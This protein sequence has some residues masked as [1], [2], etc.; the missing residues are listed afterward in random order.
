MA[1][2]TDTGYT[3]EKVAT[4]RV[5]PGQASGG[6]SAGWRAKNLRMT[7]ETILECEK[8]I[9]AGWKHDPGWMDKLLFGMRQYY[10]QEYGLDRVTMRKQPRRFLRGMAR[11]AVMEPG[12]LK[13]R[14][15]S[16]LSW[17]TPDMR[18]PHEVVR[19]LINEGGIQWP[20]ERITESC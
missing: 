4:W 10:L 8:R 18:D 7:Q 6:E 2:F 12:F 17:G 1:S 19:S 20:P 5:H 14:L 11:A 13:R 16:G 3:P 9:P 15:V